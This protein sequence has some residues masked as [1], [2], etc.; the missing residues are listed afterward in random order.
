MTANNN[1]NAGIGTVQHLA[2][3]TLSPFGFPDAFLCFSQ[4]GSNSMTASN[5]SNNKVID[6]VL[7]VAVPSLYP[8]GFPGTF[9]CF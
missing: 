5:D 1:D 6:T 9:L 2:V 8:F 3:P 4:A 7:P